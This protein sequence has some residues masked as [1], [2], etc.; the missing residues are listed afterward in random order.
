MV[1]PLFGILVLTP[2][3][4]AINYLIQD[5]PHLDDLIKPFAI[6]SLEVETRQPMDFAT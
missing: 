1:N 4:Q 3:E 6:K 5:D 2:A